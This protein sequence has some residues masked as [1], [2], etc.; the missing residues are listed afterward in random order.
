MPRR[1]AGVAPAEGGDHDARALLD[2]NDL[3][4]DP[5]ELLG[6]DVG[7]V[8]AAAARTLGANGAREAIEPLRRLARD[9]SAEE[10]ARVQ[11]GLALARLGDDE[12]ADVLRELIRLDPETG[13][14]ALEA[15]G[16][17]AQLGDPSG[18]GV[19]RQA[20]DSPNRLT[21][22]VAAKQLW[23]FAGLG[24]DLREAYE[25]ALAREPQVAGEARAQLAMPT[26]QDTPVPPSPQ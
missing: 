18:F 13:P 23:A 20:L 19:V 12:G 3:G 6:C 16:A 26:G 10:V 25:R 14:A 8:Q 1:P 24:V 17:L 5:V 2:A 22:M 9:R 7:I 4:S 11:A 21:A 15:A